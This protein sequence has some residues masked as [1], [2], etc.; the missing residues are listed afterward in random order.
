MSGAYPPAPG[1]DQPVVDPRLS[2]GAP[3]PPRPRSLRDLI[4]W[5]TEIAFIAGVLIVGLVVLVVLTSGQNPFV[6]AVIPVIVVVAL[7]AAVMRHRWMLRHRGDA[8]FQH[9]RHVARERRGF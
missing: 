6:S 4:P 8:Q 2:E 3:T 5:V 9:A 7:I 1:P